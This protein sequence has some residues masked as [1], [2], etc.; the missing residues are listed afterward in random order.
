[1]R[2]GRLFLRNVRQLDNILPTSS[3]T[4]AA[5][6][7]RSDG[8]AQI[9]VALYDG[10]EIFDPLSMGVQR[11]LSS[12]IYDYID[13]K[14]YMIPTLYE[15]RICFHGK[16]PEGVYE[17]EIRSLMTEHYSFIFRDK[18]SDLRINSLKILGLTL[19]GILFLALYFALELSS[20]EA[21]FM[22]FLSIMGTFALWEAVDC[23][24]LERKAIKIERLYAGQAVLS[25]I[26]FDHTD[27]QKGGSFK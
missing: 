26:T 20:L 4:V 27:I 22:E 10:M 12:E 5:E 21:I 25:E 6:Y 16:L 11:E 14:L 13:R 23:W 7:L 18:E 3:E 9:D 15:I 17:D 24:F 2:K 19:C 1:M 8:K